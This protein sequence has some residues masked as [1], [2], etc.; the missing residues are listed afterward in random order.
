MIIIK[1]NKFVIFYSCFIFLFSGYILWD[2]FLNTKVYQVVDN[3][4]SI[5]TNT[6]KSNN[7][8]TEITSN[9]YKDSNIEINIKEYMLQIY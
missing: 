1:N 7:N 2:T 9:T 4:S 5:N 6:S 3:S 8:K